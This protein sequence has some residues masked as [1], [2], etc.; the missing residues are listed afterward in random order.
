MLSLEEK[1]E[2]YAMLKDSISGIEAE[3]KS[4]GL[5]IKEAMSRGARPKTELY[6]AV[7]RTTYKR[8][9]PVDKFRAI[10]GDAATLEVSTI[11]AKK[12]QALVKAG[13]LDHKPL[14]GIEELKVLH[15]LYIKAREE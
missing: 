12:V 10:Y 4:L 1:L 5:E 3:I 7:L 6:E 15:A 14:A 13:D 9:Y 11:D 8:T 2:R